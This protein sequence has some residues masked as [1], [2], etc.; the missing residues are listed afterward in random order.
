MKILLGIDDTDDLDSRGTG[1]HARQIGAALEAEGLASF[2]AATRHQ[3][4]LSSE[5]AYTSRNSA[6]CVVLDASNNAIDSMREFIQKEL[7]KRS[8]RTAD[9]AFS[10]APADLVSEA[11]REFGFAAKK[12]ILTIDAAR[13][14]ARQSK[15]MLEEVGGS[16]AGAI[17]ALAAVG[18][19]RSGNDGRFIWLP[20]M[21]RLAG[22]LS[23]SDL[24][25]TLGAQVRTEA[26]EDLPLNAMIEL[27]EWIRP[28]LRQ[29][30]AI[31]LA[32]KEEL[33]GQSTWRLV[34]KPTI[35]ALTE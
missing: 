34:D 10:L 4:L 35:K 15:I 8:A 18:L 21:R 13:E 27:G 28:V 30:R 3:L 12:Q 29:G 9:P 7:R 11:A 32:E 2:L 19:H 14:L 26:G 16:G 25:E 24:G 17:G 31:L 1:H 20:N 22:K 6:A 33:N 5:I 23:L